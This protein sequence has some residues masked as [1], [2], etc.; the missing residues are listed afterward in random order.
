MNTP[1]VFLWTCIER[2][3]TISYVPDNVHLFGELILP[4]SHDEVVHGKNRSSMD[5]RHHGQ[6]LPLLRLSIL[7]DE[8][9]VKTSLYGR[10]FGQFISGNMIRN[11][12]G[13]YDYD[14]HNKLQNYTKS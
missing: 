10:K 5:V 8:A 7:H 13:C 9:R 11:S 4:L 3:V 6:K 1:K 14:S 12:T 2:I